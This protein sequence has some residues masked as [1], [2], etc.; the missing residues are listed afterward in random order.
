MILERD[1]PLM[2]GDDGWRWLFTFGDY[3]STSKN[4]KAAK[5]KKI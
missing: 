2:V 5:I 4:I 3:S 1:P